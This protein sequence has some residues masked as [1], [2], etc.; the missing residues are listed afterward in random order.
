V[1]PC[2]DRGLD[3]EGEREEPETR[4]DALG[5][6]RGAERGGHGDGED[7]GEPQ[8]LAG[9]DGAGRPFVAGAAR[10]LPAFP[11]RP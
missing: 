11:S 4:D 10:L 5:Q 1:S 6:E 8:V 9:G 3:A 7:G 2:L